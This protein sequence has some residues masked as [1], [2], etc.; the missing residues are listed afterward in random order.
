M[1]T[2]QF[3]EIYNF[4]EKV[5]NPK[6][7][8]KLKN[9]FS[10]IYKL[11]KLLAYKINDITFEMK[12]NTFSKYFDQESLRSLIFYIKDIDH[13]L[14][15]PLLKEL[16]NLRLY[17]CYQTN[18]I[19]SL[20]ISFIDNELFYEDFKFHYILFCE[21]NKLNNNFEE[22]EEFLIEKSKEK[23]KKLF[24]FV[25]RKFG[26]ESFHAICLLNRYNEFTVEDKEKYLKE[27]KL[28]L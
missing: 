13:Y 2:K 7:D 26:D 5:D 11:S 22:I 23:S 17:L 28:I 27:I 21:L 8:K 20:I 9:N 12:Y 25:I 6:L 4:Y 14:C 18:F 16:T 3:F 10:N 19:K 1:E 15:F 24:N